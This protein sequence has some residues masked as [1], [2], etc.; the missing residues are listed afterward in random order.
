VA[1][2]INQRNNPQVKQSHTI[3]N[4]SPALCQYF[5]KEK[6]EIITVAPAISGGKAFEK[7]EINSE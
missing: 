2:P 1:S 6:P 7:K 3:E 4:C 5:P